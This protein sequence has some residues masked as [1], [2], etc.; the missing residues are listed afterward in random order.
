[1]SK[2]LKEGVKNG[3]DS[4]FKQKARHFKTS[5][6]NKSLTIQQFP[7][8]ESIAHVHLKLLCKSLKL[9]QGFLPREVP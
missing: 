8:S 7:E 1:M 3:I 4:D 2:K 9:W 5:S 6:S